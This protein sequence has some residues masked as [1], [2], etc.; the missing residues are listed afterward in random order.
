MKKGKPNPKANRNIKMFMGGVIGLFL[1]M[2]AYFGYFIQVESENV[3]NNS[4]NSARLTDW[5]RA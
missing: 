5:N 1:C 3:I 2:C 4:Y